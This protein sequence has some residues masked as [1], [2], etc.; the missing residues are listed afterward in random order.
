MNKATAIRII[1]ID[2]AIY[3]LHDIFKESINSE[4][5]IYIINK[6]KDLQ[7]EKIKLYE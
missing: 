6:L 3:Q 5:Y 4:L 2:E 7:T 1:E